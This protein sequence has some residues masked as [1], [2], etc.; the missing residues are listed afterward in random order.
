MSSFWDSVVFW[1]GWYWPYMLGA[2][3][4]GV[5]TGWCNLRPARK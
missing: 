1:A 4:V 3:L 2:G 5:V